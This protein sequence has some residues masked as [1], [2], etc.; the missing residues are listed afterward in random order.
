[1]LMCY[2]PSWAQQLP[3]RIQ[4]QFDSDVPLPVAGSKAVGLAD[5]AGQVEMQ[6]FGRLV[7][8]A[9][10]TSMQAD[11]TVTYAGAQEALPVTISM[12]PGNRCRIDIT[13]SNGHDL[14][15]TKGDQGW[16]QAPQG[17]PTLD[18]P[19]MSLERTL[20]LHLFFEIQAKPNK[21]AVTDRGSTTIGGQFVHRVSVETE[22]PTSMRWPKSVPRRAVLDLYF[23]TKTHLLYKSASV[24]PVPGSMQPALLR[25]LTY[26]DYKLIDGHTVPASISETI[27]GQLIRTFALSS[28][29][30][31]AAPAASLF[32][33]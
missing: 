18:P 5:A 20:P 21:Y 29:Q 23:D 14:S 3:S 31:D 15:V 7:D 30:F 17:K 1:M 4:G 9:S 26:S 24:I 2:A 27:N 22:V 6:A 12:M 16:F 11:G 32:S 25:V 28:V 8:P 13:E 10:W 33:F 19:M